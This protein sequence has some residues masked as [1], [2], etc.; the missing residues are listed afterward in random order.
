VESFTTHDM[1]IPLDGVAGVSGSVRVR[2]LW[3]PRLLANKKA[4]TSAVLGDSS[5]YI[6]N[7]QSNI[8]EPLPR[9]S[10]SSSLGG[11]ELG[12]NQQRQS[13]DFE[14]SV[15]GRSRASSVNTWQNDTDGQSMVGSVDD[16]GTGSNNEGVP[17]TVTIK[18]VEARGVR[19]VDKSGTSDPFIRVRLGNQQIYKTRVIKKTL[20]PE[21]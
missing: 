4:F 5:T 10:L 13:L 18:L 1:D 3:H 16:G 11:S 8:T 15:G 19:G 6:D 17:G 14:T 7:G 9:S 20:R 12:Y 21:W 2:F